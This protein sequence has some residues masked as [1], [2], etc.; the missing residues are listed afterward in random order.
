MA[1]ENCVTT[2][3]DY[4]NPKPV[5]ELSEVDW[6]TI[7]EEAL[8][9][10]TFKDGD[11]YF[12]ICAGRHCIDYVNTTPADHALCQCK[13]VN[14][15]PIKGCTPPSYLYPEKATI[16]LNVKTYNP[17]DPNTYNSKSSRACTNQ[18]DDWYELTCYCCC[19]CFANGTRIAIPEGFKVI[20][21][22]LVGDKVLT[23][24]TELSGTGIK[25]NWLTAKVTFSMGTSPNSHEPV[26]VHIHHGE[27]GSIVVTPDHLFLM[28]N[29]KLKRA[30]RLVPDKID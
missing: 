6:S 22:F 5:K 20:E 24:D 12:L 2:I 30:D 21:Q 23:A 15:D 9:Q 28:P 19:S 25:L 4:Y 11:P 26:M 3:K 10:N 18:G 17:N 16:C 27:V 13:D 14:G 1:W 8:N 29:G 7:S